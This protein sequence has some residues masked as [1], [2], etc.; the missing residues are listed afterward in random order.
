MQPQSVVFQ[1][2]RLGRVPEDEL[3][4]AGYAWRSLPSEPDALSAYDCIILGDVTPE[5]LPLADRVRLEK[6]VGD[7]GGTLV[8]LAGK[9]AMPLGFAGADPGGAEGDPL[10][11]L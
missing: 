11:R 4:K 3:K 9:R 1:Q 5:Q 8:V 6:Y 10:L 7:R 2:P